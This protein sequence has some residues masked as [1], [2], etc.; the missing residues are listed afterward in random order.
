[1]RER[2][3]ERENSVNDRGQKRNKPADRLTQRWRGE[4][5]KEEYRKEKKPAKKLGSE[6][7]MK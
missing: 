6:G 1:M 2:E 5:M 7:E 4:K 3:R